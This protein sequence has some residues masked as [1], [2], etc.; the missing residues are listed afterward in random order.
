MRLVL[1]WEAQASTAAGETAQTK[2]AWTR[3]IRARSGQRVEKGSNAELPT[4]VGNGTCILKHW[5]GATHEVPIAENAGAMWD[6]QS[7][8]S[9]SAVAR[10]M[11][12]TNRIGPKFFGLREGPNT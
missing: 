1:A 9:L 6:G 3:I 7:Y 12:G 11:A 10:A 4:S 5:G 8:T 2:R